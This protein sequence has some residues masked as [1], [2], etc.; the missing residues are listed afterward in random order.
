MSGDLFAG[1]PVA[2]FAAGRAWWERFSGRP[3]DLI[4]NDN[5]AG[6]QLADRGW[7]YVIGDADRAGKALLTLVV[8]DLDALLAEL[9]GRGIEH[10][11]IKT[12]PGAVRSCWVT[13]P[14]G[15]TIQLGQPLG[16]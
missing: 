2:D 11:E 7:I 4:P 3:P 16:G 10:G 8:D 1:V 6:W 12:I 9:A 14:E 15:N 5:E 13:D